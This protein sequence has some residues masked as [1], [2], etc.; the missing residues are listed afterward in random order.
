MLI[1]NPQYLTVSALCGALGVL[2]G[3]AIYLTYLQV[4]GPDAEPQEYEEETQWHQIVVWGKQSEYCALYLRKGHGVY[5][6]G[7]LR[8]R[9]YEAKDGQQKTVYEVHAEDVRF[10]SRPYRKRTDDE[11]LVGDEQGELQAG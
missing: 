10:L 1:R 7:A 4:A 3:Y 2:S 11:S 9:S 8:S 5:L 6:E